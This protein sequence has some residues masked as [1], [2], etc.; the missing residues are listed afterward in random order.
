MSPSIYN[1]PK[2]GW[3]VQETNK[4]KRFESFLSSAC[5]GLLNFDI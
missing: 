2:G 5:G 1:A 4:G 3:L